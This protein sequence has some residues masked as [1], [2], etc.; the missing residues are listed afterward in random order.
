[1]AILKTRYELLDAVAAL[2]DCVAGARYPLA[3]PGAADARLARRELLEQL[4]DYL[5]PRL[6]HP[7]A[8]LLAVVAGCTGAGKSTLVN[9]LVR[10]E[11]SP[12]GVLR[13]TT[14]SPVLVCHP[15]DWEWFADR[16]VLRRLPRAVGD[17]EAGVRVVAAERIPRGLALLDAPPIDA[18]GTDLRRLG[19]YLVCAADIWIVVTTAARYA[20]AVPWHLLRTAREYGVSLVTVLDRVPHQVAVEVA[21]YYSAMLEAAGL[22]G[23]ASFAV[24]ELPESAGEGGLLPESAVAGVREWLWR[25][26]V[27]PQAREDALRRTVGGVLGSLRGRLSALAA[28]SAGQHAALLRLCR[29][30]EDRYREASAEISAGLGD[31]VVGGAAQARL[32][33][34]HAGGS[35]G[36]G[37]ELGRALADGVAVLIRGALDRAAEQVAGCW[38][39]DPAGFTGRDPG[40]DGGTPAEGRGRVAELVAGWLQRVKELAGGDAA[41]AVGLI[42]AALARGDEE[43]VVA[44][45]NQDL[46]R[47][48]AAL[49]RAE[50]DRR[51]ATLDEL[52]VTPDQQMSLVAAVSVVQRLAQRSAGRGGGRGGSG[53]VGQAGGI[54]LS[55]RAVPVAG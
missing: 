27:D 38:R 6:R 29:C 39:A 34:Y 48:V 14:S 22:G 20:D 36:A 31:G 53:I 51:L 49:L 26:A 19:A 44:E 15:D 5:I 23:A 18:V 17:G 30:A 3:V 41:E 45:A 12:A 33:E 4:D 10:R 16:R 28:A 42:L 35:T 54:P 21:G 11:V 47:R 2:R 24:A 7:A 55:G 32:R 40:G 13:P 1:M 37:E 52:E 25:R 46:D 43:G 9:S 8:P 50:C